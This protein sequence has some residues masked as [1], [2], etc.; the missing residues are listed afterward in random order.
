M[1][2]PTDTINE[3]PR[4]FSPHVLWHTVLAADQQ[5]FPYEAPHETGLGARG[6]PEGFTIIS[7]SD[8]QSTKVLHHRSL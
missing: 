8:N 3:V 2:V 5:R 4:R 6:D 7:A 1:V